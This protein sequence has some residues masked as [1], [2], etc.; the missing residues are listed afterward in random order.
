MISDSSLCG[1]LSSEDQNLN[2]DF[3]IQPYT[4]SKSEKS[5]E[6]FENAMDI[7]S[8]NMNIIKSNHN[9]MLLSPHIQ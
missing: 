3:Q 4:C 9:I 6:N 8:I 1:S 7:V 5:D 2:Y